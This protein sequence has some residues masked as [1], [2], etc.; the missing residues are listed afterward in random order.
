MRYQI[1]EVFEV[2]QRGAVAVVR[3]HTTI[4]AGKAL[5][6][7]LVRPD[8][9]RLVATASKEFLL[10]RHLLPQESEAFLL[11]AVPVS[12][13]PEGSWIELEEP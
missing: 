3:E 2:Q 13:V 10:R 11:R 7:T 1:V 4:P 6:A 9:S 12:Q 8:G 5:R